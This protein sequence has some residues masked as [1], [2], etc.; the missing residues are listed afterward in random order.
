M[1]KNITIILLAAGVAVLLYLLLSQPDQPDSHKQDY[2]LAQS[3]LKI[4]REQRNTGLRKID[5]LE[6]DVVKRDTLIGE[7]KSKLSITGRD[8]DRST[9]KAVQLAREIK[10]MKRDT[11]MID[12]KA[13]S[14]ATEALNYAWLYNQY[15]T[16]SDSLAMVLDKNNEDYVLALEE[17]R[18]MYDELFRKYEQLYRLYDNLFK[19]YSTARKSLKREKLK[20]KV[21]ALLAL[22]A[23]GAAVIR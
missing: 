6:R 10:S 5:S 20:T 16:N 12:S 15:K 17:R 2:E 1:T 7:L 22:V 23:G 13:D 21:A 14:L 9:A 8:L 3:D 11:T 19:D 4:V 18:K